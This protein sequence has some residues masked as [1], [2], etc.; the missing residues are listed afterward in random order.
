MSWRS[1]TAWVVAFA[2]LVVV[3]LRATSDRPAPDAAPGADRERSAK[4]V[5]VVDGD[6]I[7][8]RGRR[9]TE[10]VRY[11]GVDTP[12]S[13][14]PN[15]PVQCF[16]HEAAEFNRRLVANRTVRLVPGPEAADRYGRSLAFVY[17]D[18][19]M[20]NAELI[21]KGFARTLEIPP[22]TTRAGYFAAL[23]RVAIRTKVGLW[24]AC[25]R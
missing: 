24:R 8:V 25:D 20:V 2:L 1:A 11:I 23:E 14:K 21:R 16:G 18:R 6:T 4:V 10:R 7:V 15:T 22:N 12:E 5:R 9:G 19:L 3:A 13:V 17:V